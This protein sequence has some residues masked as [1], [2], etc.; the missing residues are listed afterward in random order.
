MIFIL[1]IDH[2]TAIISIFTFTPL[3]IIGVCP[4]SS[5]SGIGGRS[6]TTTS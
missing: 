5:S 6:R 3:I 1:I 4:R 2:A